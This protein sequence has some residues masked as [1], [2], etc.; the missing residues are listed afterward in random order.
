MSRESWTSGALMCGMF[1]SMLSSQRL[2]ATE[3]S[4]IELGLLRRE[5]RKGK[6]DRDRQR[7]R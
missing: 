3:I 4:A 7:V 2:K 5:E 1:Q 6:R